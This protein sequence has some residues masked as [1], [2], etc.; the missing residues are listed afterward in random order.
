MCQ[1]VLEI[2]TLGIQLMQTNH[3]NIQVRITH[4]L[5]IQ[6]GNTNIS[7]FVGR[8]V[9]FTGYFSFLHQ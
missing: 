3:S 7:Q 8:S 5:Q 9:V 6:W 2:H 4:Y 1:G